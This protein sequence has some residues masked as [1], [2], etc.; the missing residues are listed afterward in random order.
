MT[1]P[2]TTQP[3][4]SRNLFATAAARGTPTTA[5]KRKAEEPILIAEAQ[6]AQKKRKAE[7]PI[8]ISDKPDK[9]EVQIMSVTGFSKFRG[10]GRSSEY[11][12]QI[13]TSKT[14]ARVA[15]EAGVAPPKQVSLVSDDEEASDDEDATPAVVTQARAF[16]AS[17][18]THSVTPAGHISW[19]GPAPQ[20]TGLAT[21]GSAMLSEG[22]D[23][24]AFSTE[25]ATEVIAQAD[26]Q[27]QRTPH[28]PM[29]GEDTLNATMAALFDGAG[30]P[31]GPD[32]SDADRDE[33]WAAESIR[34]EN[35]AIDIHKRARKVFELSV[36]SQSTLASDERAAKE[37]TAQLAI[38]EQATKDAQERAIA[39]K[40]N[41]EAARAVAAKAKAD[42]EAQEQADSLALAKLQAHADA[43]QKE[44]DT[45]AQARAADLALLRTQVQAQAKAAEQASKDEL[46]LAQAQA[47]AKAA[48]E[49]AAAKALAQ[50]KA[51][52]EAQAAQAAQAVAEADE[53]LVQMRANFKLKLAMMQEAQ[54]A[55][56]AKAAPVAQ[57]AQAAHADTAAPDTETI[58]VLVAVPVAVPVADTAMT[59]A[60]A[61]P[62]AE[63]EA[64]AEPEL[65]ASQLAFKVDL[66]AVFLHTEDADGEE[67][68]P[69]PKR[70]NKSTASASAPSRASSRKAKARVQAGA[71]RK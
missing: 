27:A 4:L 12:R 22:L 67:E 42:A 35:E 24:P 6:K 31:D 41:V 40:A 59:E 23:T 52:R 57:A 54:A 2:M 64:V 53:K 34:E 45:K 8:V 26:A 70:A 60:V 33:R 20:S 1:T 49:E 28:A 30:P 29:S 19:V 50:R 43:A 10:K 56:A 14:A 32:E 48:Q 37:A 44:A 47:E 69:M 13:R 58:S 18:W 71:I 66:D 55:K 21:V 63:A 51:Q 9:P 25:A 7:G 3:I 39:A 16:I 11:R 65:T 15:R 46:D 5:N 61:V 68:A 62:V 17:G 36:A 38:E